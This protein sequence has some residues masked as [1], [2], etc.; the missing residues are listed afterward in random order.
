MKKILS[1]CLII[2]I[3]GGLSGAVFAGGADKH[4]SKNNYKKTTKIE[5]IEKNKKA[6]HH[7]SKKSSKNK[8][9]TNKSY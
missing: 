8:K 9:T 3:A 4:R 1:N 2:L 6:S 7:Q 5:K